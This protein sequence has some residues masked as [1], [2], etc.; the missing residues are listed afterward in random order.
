MRSRREV[1]ALGTGAMSAWAAPPP[2]PPAICIFS[3]HLQWLPI[4]EAAALAAEIGFDGIDITVRDG[5]HVA[6]ERVRDDLPKAVAAVRK[7]GI[8]VPMIT[9]GITDVRSA[10]AEDV[11]RTASSLG[12]RRYRWGGFVLDPSQSIP[13]QIADDRAAVR[14]LAALN[15]QYGVCA[16]YHTHSGVNLL[17]ASIWDLYLLLKDF[18]PDAVG[19]NYDIGHAHVE[20]GLGGW[21]NSASLTA[22][23]MRGVA[24]KDFY[25]QKNAKGE[26]QPRWCAIGQG[27]VHFVRFFE[28]LKSFRFP[29]PFSFTSNIR[30]WAA[31]MKA[32]V[33]SRSAGRALRKSSHAISTPCAATC[34]KPDWRGRDHNPPQLFDKHVGRSGCA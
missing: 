21:M 1:L 32:A 9:S 22:P 5:G 11:L 16:M 3:K 18:D 13:R 34:V 14:D 25:W 33:P 4:T 30:S 2:G 19:V 17:G 28:M 27:M 12:I 6:P 23:M 31:R 10:H 8:T 20:G 29:A 7:A 24:L 15:Q 26:W